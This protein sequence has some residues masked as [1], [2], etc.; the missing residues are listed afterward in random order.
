MAVKKQPNY[1][2]QRAE[3]TV[4][5]IKDI[6]SRAHLTNKEVASMMGM[7]LNTFNKRIKNPSGFRLWEL[8]NFL[9]AAGAFLEQLEDRKAGIL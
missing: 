3:A 9:Q 2:Q 1:A 5:L 4:I 6:K 8:W 7:P